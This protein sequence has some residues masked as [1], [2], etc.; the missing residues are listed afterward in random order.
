MLLKTTFFIVLNLLLSVSYNLFGQDNYSFSLNQC[1]DFALA[2]KNT[3][4]NAQLD[5]K[6]AS[7]KVKEILGLA[8]PQVE[9]NLQYLDQIKVPT[10]VI[11][12]RAFSPNAPSDAY[13]PVQF[14]I[15][16]NTTA[17]LQ[18]TQLIF[19]GTYF[20]G[21]KAARVFVELAHKNTQLSKNETATMVA[22]AYYAVLINQKR[23]ELIQTNIERLVKTLK[24][25]KLLFDNGL[26]E[27][28]DV[29]RLQVSLNNLNTEL[30]KMK[31]VIELTMNLLKFQMG[32]QN[33]TNLKL[34]EQL[35]ENDLRGLVTDTAGGVIVENRIEYQ[36]LQTQKKLNLLD[37]KRYRYSYLPKIVAFGNLQT[38]ALRQEFNFFDTQLRWYPASSIGFKLTVPIFDGFQNSGRIQQAQATLSKTENDISNLKLAVNME[39]S[40]AKLQL[41]NSLL[42]LQ[43]QQRNVDLAN[44]V[45]KNTQLKQK[46]GV[47]SNFELNESETNLKTA[48]NN[49]INSVLEA[50]LAKIDLQKATGTLYLGN[51]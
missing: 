6:S 7:G 8:Y 21:I 11:P 28:L 10:M 35:N 18:V 39:L 27:K 47:T 36:L 30:D 34:T 20:L 3:T 9:A 19:D 44:Q 33:N 14:G 4:L 12:A 2:N 37:I 51:N 45:L 38:Q 23:V 48:Q 17:T 16:Y 43:T 41:E 15:K 31:A 46:E 13:L 25:T 26:V 1:I 24:D 50:Y 32:L 22:K 40:N 49:Y 5:E 29:D 42:T